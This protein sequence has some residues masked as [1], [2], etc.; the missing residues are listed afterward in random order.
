L[1]SVTVRQVMVHRVVT[2]PPDMSV[3]DAIDQYFVVH[4]FGGFPVCSDGQ[5][6]GVLTVQ[7]VQALPTGLWPFRRVREV[8]R[9]TLPSFCIHPDWSVMQAM[10][11]MAQGGWDRLVVLENESIVGL[12]TRSSIARF[13]SLHHA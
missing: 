2:L 5:V 9:P 1:T 3:Q 10:E 13:L 11:H 12:I 4:G 7:D 8:M 6:V